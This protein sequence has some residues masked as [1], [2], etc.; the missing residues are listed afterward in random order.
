MGLAFLI[1]SEN[2]QMLSERRVLKEHEYSALL[3]ANSIVLTAK[4]EAERII[5]DAERRKDEMLRRG[6]DEGFAR[7]QREG[8]ERAYGA[9]LDTAH[10]LALSRGK[11]A[12]MVV[13]G[14]RELVG[15]FE[16]EQIFALALKRI[17]AFVRDEA[18]LVVRVAP[19]SVEV[20]KQ[21]VAHRR[22]ALADEAHAADAAV[23]AQ[24][25]RVV[26]DASLGDD[27]CVVETPAGSIDARLSTQ[28]D[29]I[30]SAIEARRGL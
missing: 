8:A 22:A 21:A 16:R 20:M 29:A 17:D 9:A 27:D 5:A 1:T 23:R 6:Y 15:E 2:L 7:G 12:D 3:D 25:V 19:A 14:L 10:A 28:I 24:A 13:R 30:R 4:K 26:A 11:M 18:F